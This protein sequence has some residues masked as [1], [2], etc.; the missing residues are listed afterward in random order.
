ML[1]RLL[2]VVVMAVS[3]LGTTATV[4]PPAANATTSP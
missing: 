3:T 2:L 4:L 1:K